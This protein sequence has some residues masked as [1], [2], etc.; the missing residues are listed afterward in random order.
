LWK[1]LLSL[2]S[3]LPWTVFAWVW[4]MATTFSPVRGEKVCSTCALINRASCGSGRLHGNRKGTGNAVEL[5]NSFG[6]PS[7]CTFNA[8]ARPPC[9]P[10]SALSSL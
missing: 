10:A 8:A 6:P 5:M 3:N 9:D 7:I 1:L 2:S 4:P